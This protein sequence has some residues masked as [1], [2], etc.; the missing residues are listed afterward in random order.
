MWPSLSTPGGSDRQISE[1]E[2]AKGE[3]KSLELEPS[4]N[5]DARYP[6]GKMSRKRLG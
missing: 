3:R 1:D 6:T 4:A 2:L 5:S